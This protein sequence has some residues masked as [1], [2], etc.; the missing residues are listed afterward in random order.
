MSDG[1][2]RESKRVWIV[3]AMQTHE[4]GL[5]RYVVRMCG[6]DVERARDVVQEAFLRLWQADRE[7]IEDH[8][9]EW[10]FSVCRNLAVDLF[11]KE[12][13]ME[14]LGSDPLADDGRIARSPSDE[15]EK[16]DSVN[17]AFEA[18][19]TLP[20]DQREVLL[21]KFQSGLSYAEI[22]RITGKSASNVGYL[23]H[24][25][26]KGIRGHLGERATTSARR[27]S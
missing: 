16:R 5:L 8:L 13:R 7:A 6:G 17:R 14:T 22:S 11:R 23:I 26:I 10:L 19:E 1:G 27:A 25:G 20:P 9:A 18:L 24:H 2:G 21:L 3:G 4:S 15:V 12:S